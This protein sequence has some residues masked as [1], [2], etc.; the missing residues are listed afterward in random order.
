MVSSVGEYTDFVYQ[1]IATTQRQL[2]GER[3]LNLL[4]VNLTSLFPAYADACGHPQNNITIDIP[5]INRAKLLTTNVISKTIPDCLSTDAEASLPYYS[6]T[7]VLY[8]IFPYISFLCALTLTLILYLYRWHHL[9]SCIK[10]VFSPISLLL[11][12]FLRLG[13]HNAMFEQSKD[14]TLSHNKFE[15]GS[16]LHVMEWKII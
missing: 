7:F 12:K 16:I 3:L 5:G 13:I 9:L 15:Q 6:T 14:T 8:K 11:W 10:L 2:T 1:Y 4:I